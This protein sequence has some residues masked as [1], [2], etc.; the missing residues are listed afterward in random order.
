MRALPRRDLLLERVR[1]E[2]RRG[3][4]VGARGASRPGNRERRRG[5]GVGLRRVRP[6]SSTGD[7]VRAMTTDGGYLREL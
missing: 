6:V 3:A 2:M 4:R 7:V 5:R 1:E